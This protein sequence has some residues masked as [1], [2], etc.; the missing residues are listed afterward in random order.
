M[1]VENNLTVKNF[2]NNEIDIV[3]E[4]IYKLSHQL[5]SIPK[6][7]KKIVERGEFE[8]VLWDDFTKHYLPTPIDTLNSIKN[9][10]DELTTKLSSVLDNFIK[11]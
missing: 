11:K 5:E 4:Q 3:N 7:L 1:S 2:L 10:L 6:S 9:E 8:Y